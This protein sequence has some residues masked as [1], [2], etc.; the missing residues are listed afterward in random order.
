[1]LFGC[2]GFKSRSSS[3]SCYSLALQRDELMPARISRT[4]YLFD[5]RNNF[6][7]KFDSFLIEHFEFELFPV[8]LFELH[9]W[10]HRFGVVGDV[11]TLSVETFARDVRCA[12]ALITSSEFGFFCELF[13]FLG[14]D[15]AAR[16]KHWQ[17]RTHIVIENE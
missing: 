14:D 10:K 1:M 6:L 5:N 2:Y 17:A 8:N 7:F 16:Q 11:T 12:H 9:R 3:G 4:Y 15:C 13:Q